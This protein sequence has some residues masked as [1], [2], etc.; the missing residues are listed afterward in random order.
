[1][2]PLGGTACVRKWGRPSPGRQGVGASDA[3]PSPTPCPSP[4]THPAIHPHACLDNTQI[5]CAHRAPHALLFAGAHPGRCRRRVEC[6]GKVDGRGRG[7][8]GRW[9]VGDDVCRERRGWG[10]TTRRAHSWCSHYW[11]KLPRPALVRQ[12][13]LSQLRVPLARSGS[14]PGTLGEHMHGVAGGSSG[15]QCWRV[16]DAKP[17]G[18]AVGAC[19]S[20]SP[21]PSP[22]P[23][24]SPRSVLV[25]VVI[26]GA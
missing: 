9:A 2:G 3:V 8:E 13:A 24:P 10:C 11:E 20:P 17:H 15:L 23:T 21:S 19:P 18:G 1:M 12:Q 6:Y 26:H 25:L 4:Q 7:G 22:S 5:A 16:A 14:L